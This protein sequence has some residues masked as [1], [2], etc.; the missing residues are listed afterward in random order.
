MKTPNESFLLRS[1]DRAYQSIEKALKSGD[2]ESG[3]IEAKFE[4]RASLKM[5]GAFLHDKEKN[6]A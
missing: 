6:N 5:N 3:L 4:L 2:H 1:M